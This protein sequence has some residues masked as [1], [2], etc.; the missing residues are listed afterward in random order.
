MTITFSICNVTSDLVDKI[1]LRK[2]FQMVFLGNDKK[3]LHIYTATIL[4]A[5]NDEKNPDQDIPFISDLK[6]LSP[7]RMHFDFAIGSN[8]SNEV[9]S[10]KHENLTDS[11]HG[12]LRE[13][14]CVRKVWGNK[15]K[16]I[17]GNQKEILDRL[18]IIYKDDNK[19]FSEDEK[20]ITANLTKYKLL[21]TE[22]KKNTVPSHL[23]H[24]LSIEGDFQEV[25]DHSEADLKD[26]VFVRKSY[27]VSVPQDTELPIGI[28][29]VNWVCTTITF[30]YGL[31]DTNLNYIIRNDNN[32][33]KVFAPDFTWYFSPI[34]KSFIDNRN[35]MVEIKR[36]NAGGETDCIC[37]IQNKRRTFYTSD[38]YQ[39]SIDGV[40]K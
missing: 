2:F 5:S 11:E 13:I 39:N 27:A 17:T 4:G 15:C 32:S 24:S 20:L 3:S 6:T 7:F 25:E 19:V 23:L 30:K 29:L 26:G 10:I 22:Q 40:T 14:D 33:T 37:P 21:W 18:K 16:I 12:F 38:K 9:L 36:G 31:D 28:E 1:I 8:D 35:C 34:V